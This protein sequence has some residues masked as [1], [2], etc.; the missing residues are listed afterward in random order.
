ML[1]DPP[2]RDYLAVILR[3]SFLRVASSAGEQLK[4]GSAI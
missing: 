3:T 1:I 2:P 4:W